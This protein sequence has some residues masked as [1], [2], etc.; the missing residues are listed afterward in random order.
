MNSLFLKRKKFISFI[1]KRAHEGEAIYWFTS[2]LEVSHFF[3]GCLAG[4]NM[5]NNNRKQVVPIAISLKPHSS[6]N[7]TFKIFP[8]CGHWERLNSSWH[9]T[10]QP[11][12]LLVGVA[13]LSKHTMRKERID[14]TLVTLT[15]VALANE[16]FWPIPT[17]PTQTTCSRSHAPPILVLGKP[18]SPVSKQP[19]VRDPVRKKQLPIKEPQPLAQKII[20]QAHCQNAAIPDSS[21]LCMLPGTNT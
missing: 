1:Q 3:M 6:D 2:P 13:C 4:N 16:P 8:S 9:P 12:L 7:K 17:N 10:T 18:H 11:C 15:R 19:R 20:T 5:A 14:H 21:C